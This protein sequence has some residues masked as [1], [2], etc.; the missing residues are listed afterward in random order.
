MKNNIIIN[1]DL[2]FDYEDLMVLVDLDTPF[3]LRDVFKATM[4]SVIPRNVIKRM[5]C[6]WIEDYWNEM[7]SKP[8]E[9]H[10]DIEY[11]ELV[12]MGETYKEE[13][14]SQDY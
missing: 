1:K 9:K 8:Y 3:T 10:N 7:E 2:R 12:L 5:I 4:Q 13:D 14:V 11:L 6:P